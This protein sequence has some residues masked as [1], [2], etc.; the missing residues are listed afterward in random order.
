MLTTRVLIKFPTHCAHITV[1]ESG[2]HIFKYNDKTCDFMVYDHE[3]Q[4]A[5]GDYAL[6][7]LP[8]VYYSVTVN[9]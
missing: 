7:N 8:T 9:D 2:I 1:G 4:L 3:E 6:E 5:A